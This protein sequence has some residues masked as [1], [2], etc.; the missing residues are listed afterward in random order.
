MAGKLR[1]IQ[2]ADGFWRS[3]LTVPTAFPNPESSGTAFFCYGLAW[4]INRGILDRATYLDTVLRAW[5]ALVSA[6]SP[7]GQ[8]GWVQPSGRCP[9]L[10]GSQTPTTTPAGRFSWQAAKC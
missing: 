10:P 7:Q 3:S 5:Q 1:T 9:D 6:V 8:I 4:G 2:G